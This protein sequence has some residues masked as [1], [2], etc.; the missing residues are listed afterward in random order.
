L[1]LMGLETGILKTPDSPVWSNEEGMILNQD[2]DKLDTTPSTWLKNSVVWYSQ[3]MTAIMGQEKFDSFVK[4]F[5]YGNK[6]TSGDEGK[7]NG[8]SRSWLM[9]SLLI[10]P[11][12]QVTFLAKM[13][14]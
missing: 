5:D 2:L 14:N 9:S 11:Q 10:S 1:A 7:N 12:E 4:Q 6:N 8:F 3:K 13:I